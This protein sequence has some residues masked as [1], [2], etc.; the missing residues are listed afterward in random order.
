VVIKG[1]LP[2]KLRTDAE[3]YAGCVSGAMQM[4]DYLE[5][6]Q[7]AGF[8]NVQ[9]HKQRSIEIPAD[10]LKMYLNEMEIQDFRSNKTGLFSITVSAYKKN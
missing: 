5:T 4:D 1:E 9:V 2:E 8:K 10:I 7:K 6:I 3:M